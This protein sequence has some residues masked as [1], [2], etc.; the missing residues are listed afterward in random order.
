MSEPQPSRSPDDAAES[1]AL[2]AEGIDVVLG[3]TQVLHG[4]DLRVGKGEIVGVLGPSGAGKSTLFRILVGE[5]NPR[6]GRVRLGSDDVTRLPLWMR[7][8]RGL[9][10][11]PQGPSVLLDL[12]VEE[13]LATFAAICKSPPAR[14][15]EEAARELGLERRLKVKASALSG[16]E[17]RCLALLRALTAKPTLLVLD[18]PFA[19]VDPPRAERIGRLLQDRAAQGAA[20]VL[21]DHRVREAVAVCDRVLLL[22]EGRVEVELPPEQFV[23]HEAVRE[24]YLGFPAS[25]RDPD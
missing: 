21:A 17:Q 12:T 13:N 25:A 4:V 10:Y 3:G 18:E 8:R 15:P 24:R 6:A 19:G 9:G 1:F 7:A 2:F 22:S 16:G 11:V 5:L 20:I 14:S 23:T